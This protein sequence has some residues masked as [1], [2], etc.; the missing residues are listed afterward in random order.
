MNKSQHMIWGAIILMIVAL[1]AS[2]EQP[3]AQEVKKGPIIVV[4]HDWTS[5][6][7]N[8]A[9]AAIIL[10]EEMGYEV[11]R[12]FVDNAVSIPGLATGDI[13]LLMEI[14]DS[15][16]G[17]H[18]QEFVE[19]KKTVENLG[20]T[21]FSGQEGWWI[22]NYVIS[23]DP[24]RG[25]EATCPGLPALEALNDCADVFATV[26][27]APKGQY[28]A[29]AVAWEPVFGDKL[30]V[31]NLGLNYE[32]V[33]AGSEAAMIAELKS[34]HDKGEP[35]LLL[36]WVPHWVH[37]PYPMTMIELPPYTPEC[38]GTTYACGWK[39]ANVLKLA[40]AGFDE[41][42]PEAAEFVRNYTLTDDQAAGIMHEV[43]L[44]GKTIDKAVRDWMAENEDVWRAWIP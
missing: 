16:S 6:L 21:G 12:R 35:I 39:A 22:P 7:I 9:L 20:L 1:V 8:T 2:A 17:A 38:W 40:W 23:G 28:L 25:I 4:E 18:I 37:I 3:A 43:D 15:V 32:V 34:A 19:E 29:G 44:G 24:E 26:E 13:H 27:T 11:E 42:F 36:M 5:Q 33:F 30:R 41:E 10:E 14:W 31:E